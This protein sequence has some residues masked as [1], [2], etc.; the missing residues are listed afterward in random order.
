[1][2]GVTE[3]VLQS[4]FF[5]QLGR[6][7]SHQRSKTYDT[8]I[9]WVERFGANANV[10]TSNTDG[11]FVANGLPPDKLPMPRGSYSVFQCQVSSCLKAMIFSV[12][13]LEDEQAFL[14]LVS[15]DL[16]DKSKVP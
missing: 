5:T 14:V 10:G 9:A 3:Q 1:M 16:V 13:L 2:A 4:C 15:E 11:L 8:P 7:R 12:P 6:V